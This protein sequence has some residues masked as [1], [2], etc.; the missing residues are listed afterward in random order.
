[1]E[2][3]ED[4][5]A[6][7]SSLARRLAGSENQGPVVL[8][9]GGSNPRELAEATARSIRFGF[10]EINLNCGCPTVQSVAASYGAALMQQAP[11]AR[12]CVQAICDAAG[13]RPVSVKCRLNA[14][15]ALEI[16]G[17]IRPDSFEALDEFVTRACIGGGASHVILH[18]RSAILALSPLKNRQVPP[19]RP[20]WAH[21][22]AALH[23][24]LRVT[25]NGGIASAADLRLAAA[26]ASDAGLDGL[27]AGRWLLRDP[28]ALLE[29]ERV[30]AARGAALG[31]GSPD[32]SA[33]D[34]AIDAMRAASAL[35]SYAAY[36]AHKVA[37][38][39]CAAS[40]LAPPLVLALEALAERWDAPAALSAGGSSD[41]GDDAMNEALD[42]VWEAIVALDGGRGNLEQGS[43][44]GRVSIR[45]MHQ[46]LGR[47][48]G[49]KVAK[50]ALRTRKEAL[51]AAAG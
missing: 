22:L 50:K 16:G 33:A 45:K 43:A 37:G 12:E 30:M 14:H 31:S 46:A 1:M 2:K 9:L 49:A 40:E 11:L 7:E 23:P 34:G 35:R 42:A 25:L 13:G 38:R 51:G 47:M 39:E 24:D 26:Q 28:F 5:L 41:W 17:A 6:S 29:A 20:E 44:A 48:A 19:L 4:L 36:A 32:T 27:M 18:A 15:D 21:R 8:Q 10:D 3:A